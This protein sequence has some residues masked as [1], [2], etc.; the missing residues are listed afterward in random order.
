MAMKRFCL[1]LVFMALVLSLMGCRTSQPE[2]QP[3]KVNQD[4][5]SLR[6]S[7]ERGDTRAQYEL[8]R[9]YAQLWNP[10]EANQWYRKA[11]EQGVADA[12]YRLGESFATGEG[13]AQDPV[14]AYAWFSLAAAQ[15]HRQAVNARTRII[16]QMSRA[17][18]DQGNG[19][20]YDYATRYTAAKAPPAPA[21]P[22]TATATPAAPK[23][24]RL[25]SP[26]D[27]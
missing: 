16:R 5:A 13:V 19:R 22:V 25:S 9:T 17:E 3:E 6:A 2:S 7:A 20:A 26:K 27:R 12:Q 10:K 1:A 18:I 11:A 15:Q 23:K 24:L 4:L 14:E 21:A 8:G